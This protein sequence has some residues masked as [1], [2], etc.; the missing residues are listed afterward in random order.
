MRPYP[1][2]IQNNHYDG[3]SVEILVLGDSNLV[4]L[5]NIDEMLT[6]LTLTKEEKEKERKDNQKTRKQI[7][8][9]VYNYVFYLE[10]LRNIT[11]LLPSSKIECL[12]VRN[13]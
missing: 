10:Q 6:Q 8:T 12:K 11:T 4:F 9:G 1:R 2:P 13:V 5:E 7:A 3:V